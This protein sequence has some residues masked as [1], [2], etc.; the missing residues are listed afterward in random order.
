MKK[1][2]YFPLFFILLLR[3]LS[4]ASKY[5][6]IV[7][8]YRTG[9]ILHAVN[10][11]APRYPASL[12]KMM[13]LFMTFDALKSGRLTLKTSLPV[14]QHAASRA[15]SKLGLRAGERVSV[16]TLILAMVTRSANDAATVIGEALG[17][18]SERRFARMM[19]I[20]AKQLGL[21]KTNFSN[22]SGL[23]EATQ[24]TTARDMAKLA[25]ALLIVHPE[26]YH[27][28]QVKKFVYK[29]EVCLT[30][31]HM[32]G[33]YAG[34][35][36]LKTGYCRASGFNIATSMKKGNQRLIGVVMG[37][38]SPQSRDRHMAYL[39]HKIFRRYPSFSQT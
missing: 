6:S 30:H 4:F 29:G 10:A 23:P 9:K 35:D 14:S 33:R 19:T 34:I 28:F 20:R 2:L 18:G 13:T 12:T 5:A 32:L 3:S 38:D 39:L 25:R 11:D 22:A 7:M 1:F 16:K 26:Y 17:Q 24:F 15:P 36:G 31:N 27:Y 37:L 8:D 21:Q